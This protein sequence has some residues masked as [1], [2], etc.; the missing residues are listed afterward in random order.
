MC[1][2]EYDSKLCI[3]IPRIW[4]F[5]LIARICYLVC[6]TYETQILENYVPKMMKTE[7]LK[8]DFGPRDE[9]KDVSVR[10]KETQSV[11]EKYRQSSDFL[12]IK[13]ISSFKM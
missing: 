5:H 10:D 12:K 6:H 3:L 13:S 9:Q 8:F 4:N 1:F 7:L 2:C 11:K